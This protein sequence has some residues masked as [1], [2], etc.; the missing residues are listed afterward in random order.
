[1]YTDRLR[2]SG[3]IRASALLLLATVIMATG[4]APLASGVNPEPLDVLVAWQD[5]M[6]T[7]RPRDA[8]MLLSEEAR[9]GLSESDFVSLY[10]RDKGEL[11]RR[12]DAMVKWA[13]EHPPAETAY[14]RVGERRLRWVWTRAGW[15]VDGAAS[16]ASDADI[17]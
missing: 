1:M 10:H 11:I 17:P 16:S 4:C 14:V 13:R 7:E 2:L 8:W 3:R 15:R 6:R 9:D 5:A 12:A